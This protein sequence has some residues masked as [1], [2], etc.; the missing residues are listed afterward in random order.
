VSCLG[1]VFSFFLSSRLVLIDLS[2]F[3][4]FFPSRLR[5]F[6]LRELHHCPEFITSLCP[7]QQE[8]QRQKKLPAGFYRFPLRVNSLQHDMRDGL[9]FLAL[10]DT[11]A[12]A[13]DSNTSSSGGGSGGGAGAASPAL[14]S[15]S[16]SASA[17]ASSFVKWTSCVELPAVPAAPNPLDAEWNETKV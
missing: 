17:A 14:A 13:A 8:Q 12:A 16:T 1:L 3:F 6:P 7:F 11:A 15:T 9:L 4:F 2:L 10:L 5:V